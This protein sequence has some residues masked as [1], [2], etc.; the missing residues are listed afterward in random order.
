MIPSLS[1]IHPLSEF[2]RGAKAFL[3]KLKKTKTPIVLTVNG[4][5]A[6]VVQDAESYQQLLDRI[7]L[8]ESIAG[9]RKSIEEFERGEGMPLK[10]AFQQLQE[11]YGIPD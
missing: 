9:I 2:Q 4:K 3:I 7:E 1:D 8:L 11:K 10:Q 6:A 5:A